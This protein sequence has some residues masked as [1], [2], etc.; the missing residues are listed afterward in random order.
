[1]VKHIDNITNITNIKNKIFTQNNLY[2]IT[3]LLTIFIALWTIL[4]AIPSLF[5]TIFNTILG[6]LIL[7]LIIILSAKFNVALS[8]GLAITFLIIYQFSHMSSSLKEGFS[9]PTSASSGSTTSTTT[10]KYANLAPLPADNIWSKETADAYTAKVK[11]VENPNLT[12]AQI[13]ENIS[14]L[15]KVASDAEASAFASTGLWPWD[16]FIMQ[17]VTQV[18]TDAFTN[19][20]NNKDKTDADKQQNVSNIIKIYQSRL[21]NRSVF[22][23]MGPQFDSVKSTPQGQLFADLQS[24]NG[25]DAGNK[26]FIKCFGTK[27]LLY[28]PTAAGERTEY[29]M[30]AD[31]APQQYPGVETN[32]SILPKLISGLKFV[33][34]SCNICDLSKTCAFSM[35][36]TI[37]SPWDIY[38]GTKPVGSVTESAPATVASQQSVDPSKFPELNKIKTELNTLFP[39]SS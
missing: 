25:Y 19:D 14:R 8:I 2:L 24:P 36:G 38:W 34:D 13:A 11:I 18:F 23:F 10:S 15:Q 12:D 16:D 9:F 21:P 4:Y 33:N 1:M 31:S 6:N 29:T 39:S 37:S 3:G 28:K 26:T 5:I 7:V 17:G 27:A 30:S 22:A 32:Y 20:P 35:N